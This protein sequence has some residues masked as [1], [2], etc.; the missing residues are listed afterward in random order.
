M[1]TSPL[2]LREADHAL[3]DVDRAAVGR[4]NDNISAFRMQVRSGAD[5]KGY[6]EQ[7]LIMLN[8]HSAVP[9]DCLVGRETLNH[10][11]HCGNLTI[12]PEGVEFQGDLGAP[13]N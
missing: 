13:L 2:G 5:V 6:S 9:V 4:G 1:S 10:V 7:N 8:R 3:I 11:A 12:I